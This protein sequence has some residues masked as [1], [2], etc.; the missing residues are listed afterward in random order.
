MSSPYE[1]RFWRKNGDEGIWE[2]KNKRLS[3]N[4]YGLYL[5]GL[6]DSIDTTEFLEE[7]HNAQLDVFAFILIHAGDEKIISISGKSFLLL[8]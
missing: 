6:N 2:W 5:H 3:R 7:N 4:D 8:S 1:S